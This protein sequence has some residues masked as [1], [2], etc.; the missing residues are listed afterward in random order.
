MTDLTGSD[1]RYSDLTRGSANPRYFLVVLGWIVVINLL[2]FIYHFSNTAIFNTVSNTACIALIGYAAFIVFRSPNANSAT[3]IYLAAAGG[4]TLLSIGFNGS[5][6][7]ITDAIKYLSIY[8]FYAAGYVSASQPSRIETR[9]VGLLAALPLAFFV[10]IGDSRVP[11]FVLNNL[12]NTFSYFANANIATLYFGALIFTL[13]NSIGG[14]AILLQFANA[15]LM[16]KIGP[17]IATVVAIGLWIAFPLRKQSLIALAVSAIAAMI[18]LWAGALDRIIAVLETMRV[19]ADLGP[20]YVSRMS[21]KRLVE[22]TGTTDLSGFF[23]VI[24]WANIWEIYSSSGFG[25][26]L[27]GYGVGQTPN[28]TVLPFIPHND[29]LRILVEYGP[30]NLIVFV[31]FLM[32]V[33]LNLRTGVTKV[34]FM[35]LLIYF[36]SENLLDHFASMTLYFTYAGRFASKPREEKSPAR[37]R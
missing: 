34:L 29:Y 24:H 2:T 9:I 23:R 13:A 21:F 11:E 30:L 8:V 3:I 22:L 36:F 15:V 17:A 14:G 5:K 6:A 31:C 12:G 27:F 33:L 18:A 37:A 19:L 10:A 26:L 28:L 16:N 32:H 25:T 4:L 1:V 35:V 7:S 20:E